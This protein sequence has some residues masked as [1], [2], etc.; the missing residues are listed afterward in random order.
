MNFPTVAALMRTQKQRAAAPSSSS[1]LPY[2]RAGARSADSLCMSFFGSVV[3]I[4]GV[5]TTLRIPSVELANKPF[6]LGPPRGR[7]LD[8]LIF[9]DI[10]CRKVL[11]ASQDMTICTTSPTPPSLSRFL[12]FPVGGEQISW[13]NFQHTGNDRDTSLLIA[14]KLRK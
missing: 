6:L 2:S 8:V 3:R 1:T 4:I 13:R 12:S 10:V 14:A 11:A 9:I 5:P 7:R